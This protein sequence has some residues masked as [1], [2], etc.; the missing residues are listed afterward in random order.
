MVG[1]QQDVPQGTQGRA[2][3]FPARTAFRGVG[4]EGRVGSGK[5][6]K[7]TGD[8][9]STLKSR[10]ARRVL[11]RKK[12]A[13]PRLEGD[14]G[15]AEIGV[16]SRRPCPPGPGGVPAAS[17]RPPAGRR[18]NKDPATAIHRSL[19]TLRNPRCRRLRRQGVVSNRNAGVKGLP[20]P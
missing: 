15:L 16:Q 5:G 6:R 20:V 18:G 11:A 7:A 13:T 1:R 10:L 12:R 9:K 17:P 19:L 8:G 3:F 14:L 2:W 4:L